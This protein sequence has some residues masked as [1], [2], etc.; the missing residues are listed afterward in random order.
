M[1]FTDTARL[2]QGRVKLSSDD[3][4]VNKECAA[5]ASNDAEPQLSVAPREQTQRRA[6]AARRCPFFKLVVGD[7]DATWSSTWRVEQSKAAAA[8]APTEQEHLQSSSRSN[9]GGGGGSSRGDEEVFGWRLWTVA[10]DASCGGLDWFG[11]G[12]DRWSCGDWGSGGGTAAAEAGLSPALAPAPAPAP[13]TQNSTS[14]HQHSTQQL[15][16]SVVGHPCVLLSW[17]TQARSVRRLRRRPRQ[18]G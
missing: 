16:G 4:V 18:P 15:G 6:I 10:A 17:C 5:A 7:G 14:E 1:K 3:L 2:L 8:A 13:A 9:R 11:L 12:S